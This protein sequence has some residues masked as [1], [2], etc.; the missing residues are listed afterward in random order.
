MAVGGLHRKHKEHG[1]STTTMGTDMITH[2]RHV[3]TPTGDKIQVR[4]RL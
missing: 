2:A 3:E 1:R 4:L